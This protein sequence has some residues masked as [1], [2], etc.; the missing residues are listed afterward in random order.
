[1]VISQEPARTPLA[2]RLVSAD[3]V[4]SQTTV[5]PS[6]STTKTC[7]DVDASTSI[8]P[9]ATA[10]HHLSAAPGGPH[11]WD[12]RCLHHTDRIASPSLPPRRSDPVSPSS[13]PVQQ[14]SVPPGLV[15]LTAFP[16]VSGCFV[17]PCRL[18]SRNRACFSS[19]RRCN[20]IESGQCPRFAPRQTGQ[21]SGGNLLSTGGVAGGSL[22]F[23]VTGHG[24]VPALSGPDVV[25]LHRQGVAQ[26]GERP[27]PPRCRR[28]PPRAVPSPAVLRSHTGPAPPPAALCP[29]RPPAPVSV[30]SRQPGRTV[31]RLQQSLHNLRIYANLKV[32]HC[33]PSGLWCLF[34]TPHR[35]ERGG[36]PF[37]EWPP[38]VQQTRGSVRSRLA[39]ARAYQPPLP[40]AA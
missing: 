25:L 1:M 36:S 28:I 7:P 33:H 29:P 21:E 26:A 14:C 27:L 13:R 2:V 12:R 39:L 37:S 32:S 11:P 5:L 10:V 4:S 8:S 40:N 6:S 34:A 19:G 38:F 20:K 17:V 30:C 3:R 23:R 35:S 15:A 9:F 16:C 18:S 24:H 31:L 22:P